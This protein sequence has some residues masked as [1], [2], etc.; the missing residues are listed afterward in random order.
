MPPIPR[1]QRHFGKVAEHAV[2]PQGK[3]LVILALGLSLVVRREERLVTAER[4]RVDEQARPVGVRHER[5]GGLEAPVRAL[6]HDQSLVRTDAVRIGRDLREPGRGGE[7]AVGAPI[8]PGPP[9]GFEELDQGE[10][11]H[12]PERLQIPRREGL[13]VD[14]RVAP[15]VPGAMERL[16][17]RL[18]QG[19]AD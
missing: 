13:D 12:P 19:K 14:R 10:V 9:R 18:L 17:E 11:G 2:H 8:V 15:P 7:L 5:G 6:R 1:P 4:P 3:E 16:H